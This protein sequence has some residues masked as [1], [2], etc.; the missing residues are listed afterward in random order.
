MEVEAGSWVVFPRQTPHF[1]QN[2][3]ESDCTLI[4][5]AIPGGL[6]GYFTALSAAIEERDGD[7]VAAVNSQFGITFLDS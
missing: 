7:A 2:S 3:G 4:I 6:D 1:F 5:T